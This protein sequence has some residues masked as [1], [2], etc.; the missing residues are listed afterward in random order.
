[1]VEWNTDR[2][3]SIDRVVDMVWSRGLIRSVV[4]LLAG[5]AA[6]GDAS[7][8]DHVR[9]RLVTAAVEL[10][11]GGTA[12]V[13]VRFD[14]D[15]G[16]HIYWANPGDS[17]LATEVIH[18]LP[19]GFAVG[20][21]LWPLPVEFAQPGDLAG[22]GYEGTVVLAAEIRLPGLWLRRP[23]SSQSVRVLAGLQRR[24][25]AR[26]GGTGRAACGGFRRRFF[27]GME[28]V[29]AAAEPTVRRDRERRS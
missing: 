12:K 7:G 14:I 19:D 6:A 27:R 29:S 9:A 22:F 8:E 5:V 1:M 21:V 24:L 15:P 17:G 25:R 20:D 11:P 13:G 26:L 3:V 18:D 2:L 16:W 10:Q 23:S 4:I 28:R